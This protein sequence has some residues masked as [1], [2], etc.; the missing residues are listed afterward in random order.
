MFHITATIPHPGLPN[1]NASLNYDRYTSSL[2]LSFPYRNPHGVAGFSHID[3]TGYIL[4]HAVRH[5]QQRIDALRLGME[6]SEL[7][8]F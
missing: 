1:R 2:F 8:R 4:A 3:I 6:M 5:Y 7:D